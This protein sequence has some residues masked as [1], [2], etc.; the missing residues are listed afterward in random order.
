MIIEHVAA[1]AFRDSGFYDEICVSETQTRKHTY[2]HRHAHT[3]THTHAHTHT[4]THTH[5]HTHTRLH[6]PTGIPEL[7]CATYSTYGLVMLLIKSD[8]APT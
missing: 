2:T 7:C 4:H 3:H 5:I 6:T 8:L 1:E